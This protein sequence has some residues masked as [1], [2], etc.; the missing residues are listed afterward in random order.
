MVRLLQVDAGISFYIVRFAAGA[1]AAYNARGSTEGAGVVSEWQMPPVSGR[2]ASCQRE[3]EPGAELRACLFSVGLG[4][5][6]RDYCPSCMGDPPADLVG[7]W[8]AHRPL[9]SERRAPALDREALYQLFV[10][11]EN[12]AR[13]GAKQLRF[14][15]ALL[16]WRRKVLWLESTDPSDGA[17]SWR[18][19]ARGPGTTHVVER[20][21]IPADEMERLSQQLECL[22]AGG[23][24]A[25]SLDDGTLAGA[26]ERGRPA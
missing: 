22:V 15:L 10:E 12:T 16:L 17:E 4:Y 9:G 5:Q 19:T 18:Y 6:R 24:V 21:A 14:V 25:A 3:F 1:G 11:L 13:E 26:I 7:W 8:K 2:C 23:E 20:P